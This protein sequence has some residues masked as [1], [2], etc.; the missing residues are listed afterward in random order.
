VIGADTPAASA[1]ELR[2]GT[3]TVALVGFAGFQLLDVTGPHEVFSQAARLLQQDDSARPPPYRVIFCA[4]ERGNIPCSSGLSLLCECAWRELP[5]VDTLL[6]VG[7]A[8]I[9]RACEDEAL[10]SWLCARANQSRRFGSICTGAILLG[11]AGVLDGRRVTTHWKHTAELARLVPSARVASEAIFVQDGS[12]WTSAGVLAGMDMA[13]AMVEQDWG[14]SLALEVARR[15][16]MYQQRAGSA[17]QR[18]TA[19][20]AQAAA[21]EGRFRQLAD[22]IPHHLAEDLSVPRLA[23]R[24]DMSP[25]H[26]ARCFREELGV[27]PAKFIEQLRFEAARQALGEGSASVEDVAGRCGF[28][29][30]ETL[31]R[32]FQRRLG[33]GP[34]AYRR[35]AREGQHGT[36]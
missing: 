30:A 8:G 3:R 12:L 9:W 24:F 21:A 16:V 10:L 17:A 11:H 32:V 14:K 6:V 25:R 27:T 26:F 4:P 23:A 34:S 31:R 22:W 1:E 5:Q 33:M 20:E 28:G 18:S 13:L 15:L 19:L 29:C 36:A 7:G 2:G 35:Q